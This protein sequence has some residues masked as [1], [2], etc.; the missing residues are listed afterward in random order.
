MFLRHARVPDVAFVRVLA[1]QRLERGAPFLY[2]PDPVLDA[3]ALQEEVLVLALRNRLQRALGSF[4]YFLVEFGGFL[5]VRFLFSPLVEEL[6]VLA[7]GWRVLLALLEVE[8]REAFCRVPGA[9]AFVEVDHVETEG[10][11]VAGRHG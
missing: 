11:V 2:L 1:N 5:C 4:N 7:P 9:L 3:G 8:H 6:D 10:G